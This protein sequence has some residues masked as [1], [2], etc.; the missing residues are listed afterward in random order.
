[1]RRRDFLALAS[2][3]ALACSAHAQQSARQ[4]R[5]GIVLPG[6]DGTKIN[7]VEAEFLDGLVRHGY[8]EG[9]NLIVD[10]YAAMGSMDRFADL[11]ATVVGNHPEVIVT[12]APPMT[13]ALKAATQTIPIVTVIGDPV[14]LGLV[15]SLARPGGNVTGITVDAGA[16]LSGKRLSL[17]RETRPDATRLAYL[18]SSQAMQQPQA[19][20][21]K[22][23]AE[24]LKLSFLHVDLGN[25]LNERAY[26]AA[27]DS[28]VKV[29]AELLLVSDEPQHLPNSKVLVGIATNAQIPAMYPFRDLVVAGGLM[30]Y[31]R[32]LFDAFRQVADQAAQIL[33]GGNPAEM[34]FR[35][36]TSFKFSISTKAAREIGITIPPTLLASADEVIE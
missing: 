8:V 4:R 15:S 21:A 25:S 14:A 36:P 13:L 19:A 35:Q 28:V 29:G 33:D 12:G 6:W 7:P 34:P 1:M 16:E 9:R 18:S 26:K 27:Y 32:D 3:S 10:R 20:M 17:L 30:A 5:I 31:Y 2:A 22:Q 24:E 23:A 11:A